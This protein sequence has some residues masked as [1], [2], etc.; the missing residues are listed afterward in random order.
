MLL[1]APGLTI[2]NKKLVE[3]SASLLVTSASLLGARMLLGAPGSS[4]YSP[5]SLVGWRPSTIG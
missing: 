2:S 4:F 3:T 5:I 1:G